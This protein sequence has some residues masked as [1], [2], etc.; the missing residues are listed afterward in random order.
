MPSSP[1]KNGTILPAQTDEDRPIVV[2]K[3]EEKVALLGEEAKNSQKSR[4]V[5]KEAVETGKVR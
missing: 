1:T 2:G 5:E 3:A 4:L